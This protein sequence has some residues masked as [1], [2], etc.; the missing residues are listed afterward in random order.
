MEIDLKPY[1]DRYEKLT[2]QADQVFEKVKTAFPG[3]VRCSNGVLRLLSG[4]F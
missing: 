4:A 1:F 3:E 2:V